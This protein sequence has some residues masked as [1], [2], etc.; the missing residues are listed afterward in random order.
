MYQIGLV[1]IAGDVLDF[2]FKCNLRN[3]ALLEEYLIL[4]RRDELR[5]E[6]GESIGF[7]RTFQSLTGSK[8]G[9]A[10]AKPPPAVVA[11]DTSNVMNEKT[12]VPPPPPKF[13]PNAQVV[14]N[15]NTEP[16]LIGTGNDPPKKKRFG[17][18]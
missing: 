2:F 8:L 16:P 5:V 13:K 7:T 9:K 6:R 15:E 1:P 4:R 11:G 14:G 10:P 18:F 3:A 12:V 17:F